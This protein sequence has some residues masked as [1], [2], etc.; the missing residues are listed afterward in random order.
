MLLREFLQM[1]KRSIKNFENTNL[2]RSCKNAD[3]SVGDVFV[4]H[5]T[6]LPMYGVVIQKNQEKISFAYL[7]TFLPLASIEAVSLKVEDL[8]KEVKLTHLIFEI[9]LQTSNLFT[10]RLGKVKDFQALMD[11]LEKLKKIE[12]GNIHR[13]FFEHESNRVKLILKLM[14]EHEKI[15]LLSTEVI[16]KFREISKQVAV[17]ATGKKTC[18]IGCMLVVEEELGLRLFFSDDCEGKLGQIILLDEVIFKGHLKSG[19]LLRGLKGP[20]DLISDQMKVEIAD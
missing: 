13:K 3:L 12:Y 20:V 15:V 2:V 5:T 16:R 4:V 17:A 10:K 19:L 6:H 7:T 1:Y 8:F 11:N 14:N 18:R 9:D